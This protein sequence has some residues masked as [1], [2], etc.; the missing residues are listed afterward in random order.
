MKK[1]L[2][3]LIFIL[4]LAII[5]RSFG[6][7]EAMYDDEA[8]YAF[9]AANAGKLGFNPYHY[10]PLIAQWSNILSINTFGINTFAFRLVPLI[11][12]ILTIIFTYLLAKEHY[13]KKIALLTSLIMS[14]SFYHIL[15]SLQI[16][17]EGSILTFLFVLT[18]FSYL[19]YEKYKTK[20]WQILTG[21][22]IGLS[23]LAKSNSIGLFIIIGAHSLFKNKKIIK[24]IKDLFIPFL[25]GVFIL[26][27]FFLFA[28]LINPQNISFLFSHGTNFLNLKPSAIPIFLF[29]LWA[30]P[31]LV[32]LA[33]IRI[34]K[35]KKEDSIFI[36]WIVYTILFYT[37]IIKKGDFSRYF[38]NLIPA[39]SILGAITLSK[40]KIKNL[41][42]ISII[43]AIYLTI[44]FLITLIPIKYV[45]RFFEIYLSEIKNLNFNFLFS[46]TT[47][48][49]PTF[50]IS[51]LP[52]LLTFILA[53][54]FILLYFLIKNKKAKSIF[55]IIFISTSLGF[56][57]FLTQEYLFHTTGPDVS[58]VQNEMIKYFKENNLNYPLYSNNEGI[59]FELDNN[60]HAQ[61]RTIFKSIGIPDN[62]LDAPTSFP[63]E[64]IEKNGGA[65]LLLNWPPILKNSPIWEITKHCQEIK[66][67]Y[68]KGIL[69][70]KIYKC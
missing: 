45:P 37:F 21:I 29:L 4:L 49:G 70:G 54:I 40:L 66:E 39:L 61:N 32:G 62:E 52:I 31:F 23:F 43:S 5:L 16:D 24:T 35:L 44:L 46:Y 20:K 48:S 51:F 9:A 69:I 56:N 38:M 1:T 11:F 10:S 15:A 47:S 36:I 22:F 67:F 60:Y 57:V 2:K 17:V 27:L 19:K 7:D 28:Y 65:I 33:L 63:E 18:I 14:I 59:M 55:L 41:K 6:L 58:L 50:G 3:I 42:L 26:G 13:N 12:G 30:T 8:T 68:S 64:M 53:G 34:I 25:I